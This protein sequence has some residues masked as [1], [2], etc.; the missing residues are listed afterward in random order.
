MGIKLQH[1]FV[2]IFILVFMAGCKK[3]DVHDLDINV[4]TFGLRLDSILAHPLD[5][6]SY[7][8]GEWSNY[9]QPYL[10]SDS[11]GGG[12]SYDGFLRLWNYPLGS[13]GA[14]GLLNHEY[15][16]LGDNHQIFYE[17]S[18]SLDLS[19]SYSDFDGNGFPIGFETSV[20]TGNPSSGTLKI[21]LVHNPDKKAIGVS[22]GDISNAG[23][24]IDYTYTFNVAIK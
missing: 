19:I 21:S 12:H 24:T 13:T 7:G 18:D 17:V 20:I 11:I 2:S 3:D 6:L 15:V 22:D 14:G 5:Y 8:N 23:G 9:D 16:E 4:I 10:R 1:V